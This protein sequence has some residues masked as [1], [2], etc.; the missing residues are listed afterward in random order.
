MTRDP[1]AEINLQN[2]GGNTALYFAV[3]ANSFDKTRLLIEYEADRNIA[4]QIG[5]TPL[6]I[7]RRF[8]FR[9]IINLLESYFSMSY[10]RQ[11]KPESAEGDIAE[12]SPR[13]NA[14]SSTPRVRFANGDDGF[15]GNSSHGATPRGNCG[16]GD[17]DLSS[18]SYSSLLNENI[19]KFVSGHEGDI[20]LMESMLKNGSIPHVNVTDSEGWT[21]SMY[22]VMFGTT[23]AMEWLHC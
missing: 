5:D 21:A 15:G 19:K 18:S 2:T 16:D 11:K 6:R 1:P 12:F 8:K 17:G 10:L 7:A 23:E 9:G 22:Q 14:S 4:D 13:I 20:D 3:H